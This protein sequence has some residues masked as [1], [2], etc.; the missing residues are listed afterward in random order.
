MPLRPATPSDVPL[1]L[2]MVRSL[3]GEHAARDPARFATLP[4]VLDR[5][6]R[7][8]PIRATD[9]RS[10]FLVAEE[11]LIPSGPS[12]IP[13]AEPTLVAFAVCSVEAAIPIYA[14]GEFGWVHDLY[15]V[16]A[17]RRQGIARALTREV[18]ARFASMGVTQIRLETASFNDAARATFAAEGFRVSSIEMLRELSAS[19]ATATDL[20]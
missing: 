15:V 11:P 14:T 12:S 17:A 9:P 7:W 6:A 2:P 19:E 1:V 13:G 16:P 10:V 18:I 20:R 5:Y 8:L 4:D 3:L